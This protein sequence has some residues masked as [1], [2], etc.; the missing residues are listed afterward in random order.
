MIL[1]GPL[2][3]PTVGDTRHFSLLVEDMQQNGKF[4]VK[5]RNTS[6]GN[7]YNKWFSNLTTGLGILIDVLLH[8]WKLDLISFHAS[9][10][11]VFWF[12]PLLYLIARIYKKPIIIRLFGGRFSEYY[13]SKK[14]LG[15]WVLQ[16]TVL[17]SD[18]ILLQTKH[19][20]QFFGPISSGRVEHF[21]TYIRSVTP[22]RS[23]TEGDNKKRR[24]EH[25]VFLGHLWKTK[26]IETILEAAP[27][28]PAGVTIDLFGPMDDYTVEELNNRGYGRV[29]YRGVL[30]QE[31][32]AVRLWNYD[33]LMLPTFHPGEGYPGAIAEAFAHGLPV[34]TTQW[35]SIPEIVDESCGLLIEP[36]NTPQ[37]ICAIKQL[38][39]NV[40]LWHHLKRGAKRKTEQF[41]DVFW[42]KKFVSFCEALCL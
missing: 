8:G 3:P 26:G 28:L 15:K 23:S 36:N 20:V 22:P 11:G 41:S 13:L 25:F 1:I 29:H 19:Q 37:F 21:S 38:N 5:V 7:K 6:R 42:T 32:V 30:T 16:K 39:E 10:R 18:M 24:C 12:G 40:E 27:Y 31:E 33:A 35:M 9:E 2:P 4:N 17:K 34:I 14:K